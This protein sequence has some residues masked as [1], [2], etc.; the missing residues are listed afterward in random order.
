M[1][2]IQLEVTCREWWGKCWSDSRPFV[3]DATLSDA[4]ALPNAPVCIYVRTKNAEEA[5]QLLRLAADALEREPELLKQLE[6]VEK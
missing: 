1:K 2:A 6:G 3:V 4:Q 5:V